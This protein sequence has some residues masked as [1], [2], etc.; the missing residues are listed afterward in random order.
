ARSPCNAP[1][2]PRILRSLRIKADELPG[3][4]FRRCHPERYSWEP[5]GYRK[6]LGWKE[7]LLRSRDA[8]RST[9]QHDDFTTI[10]LEESFHPHRS[11]GDDG[12][13]GDRPAG[14]DAGAVGFTGRCIQ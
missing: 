7:A 6:D 1:R 4:Y 14:D 13:D 10:A 5:S 9:A 8:S 11:P 12:A 2:R 3:L